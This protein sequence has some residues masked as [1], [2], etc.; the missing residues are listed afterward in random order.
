MSGVCSEYPKVYIHQIS[1]QLLE[2]GTRSRAPCPDLG[3]YAAQG[4]DPVGGSGLGCQGGAWL[5]GV[6]TLIFHFLFRH[7]EARR[8]EGP[9]TPSNTLEKKNHR[10]RKALKAIANPQSSYKA[11]WKSLSKGHTSKRHRRTELQAPGRHAARNPSDD[12]S[13]GATRPPTWCCLCKVALG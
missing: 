9:D 12:H 8:L 5:L 11:P 2:F 3:L 10:C 7:Q 1:K 13:G 4:L 6:R